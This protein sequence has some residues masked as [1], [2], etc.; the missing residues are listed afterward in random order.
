[1]PDAARNRPFLTVEE[2]PCLWRQVCRQAPIGL[3]SIRARRHSEKS[4][5]GIPIKAVH[6]RYLKLE[7]MVLSG[8][9]IESNNV[10]GI[11]GQE[12]QNPR[13]GSSQAENA[14]T[15]TQRRK[16]GFA[17]FIGGSEVE[18]CDVFPLS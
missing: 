4:Q 1:M 14:L 8:V 15:A 6:G 5:T 12:I 16:L 13:S 3:Q 11:F 17:V 10:S 7:K 9:Q 2:V 18:R